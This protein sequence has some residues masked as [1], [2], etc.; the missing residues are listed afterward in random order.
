MGFRKKFTQPAGSHLA[1]QICL[2]S[3]AKRRVAGRSEQVSG[4]WAVQLSG[5]TRVEVTFQQ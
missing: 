2:A 1:R 4:V 5:A 3:G